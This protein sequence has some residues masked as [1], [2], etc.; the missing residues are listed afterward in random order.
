MKL[1]IGEKSDCFG[2]NRKLNYGGINNEKK[3]EKISIIGIGDLYYTESVC[4]VSFI[5]NKARKFGKSFIH[6]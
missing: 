6:F 5:C 1:C 3:P 4:R 2:S